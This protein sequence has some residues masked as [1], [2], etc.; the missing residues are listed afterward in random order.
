MEIT[1]FHLRP[2]KMIC[3]QFEVPQLQKIG[4]K[5][6]KRVLFWSFG[7]T[8]WLSWHFKKINSQCKWSEMQNFDVLQYILLK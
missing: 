2:L 8:F 7:G 1:N 5:E 4:Q 6:I 3:E